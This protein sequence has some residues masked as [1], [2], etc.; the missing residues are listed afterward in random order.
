[1]AG[2]ILGLAGAAPGFVAVIVVGAV[3]LGAVA[4]VL[5]AVAEGV[6]VVLVVCACA[7]PIKP[8][9]AASAMNAVSE[10]CIT[11]PPHLGSVSHPPNNSHA[12]LFPVYE[13]VGFAKFRSAKSRKH[14][15]LAA[16]AAGAAPQDFSTGKISLA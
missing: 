15:Y 3:A 14:L 16:A 6:V 11:I 8:A 12:R 2:A 4:W 13:E 10:R 1:L 5:G 7:K 9:A